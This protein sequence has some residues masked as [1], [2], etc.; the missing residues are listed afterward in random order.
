MA[1]GR[2]DQINA[3]LK[4]NYSNIAIA[5]SVAAGNQLFRPENKSASP[6]IIA[7]ESTWL[8]EKLHLATQFSTELKSE[9]LPNL[10]IGP[11]TPQE[12][13]TSLDPMKN[14]LANGAHIFIPSELVFSPK[15]LIEVEKNKIPAL[16]KNGKP[17]FVKEKAITRPKLFEE[18]G[19]FN[20]HIQAHQD[21]KVP[22]QDILSEFKEYNTILMA[23]CRS[24]W[25]PKS[26]QLDTQYVDQK[27]CHPASDEQYHTIYSSTGKLLTSLP[28]KQKAFEAP[29]ALMLQLTE[30]A[31]IKE[32]QEIFQL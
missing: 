23:T 6:E 28:A 12:L 17:R 7:K 10:F 26:N 16:D 27:Q 32:Q 25:R 22:L 13:Q 2:Q 29:P 30:K 14:A 15:L 24:P 31:A 3:T 19:S 21:Q 4:E 8:Q 20:D 18:D 11:H 1:H 5:F 9:A